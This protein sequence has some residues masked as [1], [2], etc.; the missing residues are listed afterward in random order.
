[1]TL[2]D[3]LALSYYKKVAD[4]NPE[5]G[6]CLIQHQETGKFYVQKL[7]SAY[8]ISVFRQLMEHPLPGIPRIYEAV[9]EDAY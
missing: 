5:H 1:M 9:E 6:I 8:N 4:I 2:T 3:S 7:L